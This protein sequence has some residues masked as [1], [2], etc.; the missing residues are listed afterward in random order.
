MQ[1]IAT[2]LDEFHSAPALPDPDRAVR[3]VEMSTLLDKV[4]KFSGLSRLKSLGRSTNT[5]SSIAFATR[6]V[7]F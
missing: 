4:E 1:E 3:A 6:H 7:A 2:A 5:I